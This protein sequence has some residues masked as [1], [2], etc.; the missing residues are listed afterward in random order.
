[1][2]SKTVLYLFIGQIIIALLLLY[3]L[4]ITNAYGQAEKINRKSRPIISLRA[5]KYTKCSFM[6]P[7]LRR[8]IE[9]AKQ[10]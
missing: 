9:Q 1:M 10:F 7:P 8:G 3:L 4:P 6:C 2:V 5:G